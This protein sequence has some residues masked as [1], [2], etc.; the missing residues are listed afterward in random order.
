MPK[1]LSILTGITSLMGLTALPSSAVAW[2]KDGH[3][4]VG[5]IA[6]KYLNKKARSEIED[7]LEGHQ[8]RSLSEGKLTNWADT[9][10]NSSV[11]KKKYPKMAQW[12]YIDI[13]VDSD[14]AML[15]LAQ[16]C[17]KGNCV[18]DATKSFQAILK[19]PSK[20]IE[21]RREALFFIAHFIG[22][23][24]QPL[25][26]AERNNDKGG[27]LVKVHLSSNDRH[28]TN[29]HKV[30]DTELVEEAKGTL[31]LSDYATRLATTLSTDTRKSY[32]K[33]K[34]EDWI[35]EGHKIAREKVYKDKNVKI[36]GEGPPHTLSAEYILEG[37]EIV[38]EQLTKGGVRLAQFL[39]DT[40]KE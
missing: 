34:L 35:L 16:F 28:V 20:P 2:G 18:L 38:E 22:D 23:L 11:F 13:D 27:N 12:H 8:F 7:L 37:A 29:L 30:W 36:P 39:N 26:C 33:G 32:Q 40:F 17:Q 21:D 14:L 15:D 25:H 3:E 6:D 19:D 4:L 24:H 5:K 1:Y 31:T 9:I 10:K